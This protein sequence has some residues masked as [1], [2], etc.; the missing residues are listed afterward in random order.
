[1]SMKLIKAAEEGNVAVIK[2]RLAAGDDIRFAQKGTGFN[3]LIMAVYAGQME[4]VRCLIDESSPLDDLSNVLGW[5]ALGWAASHGHVQA[6]QMLKDAGADLE[7]NADERNRTPYLVAIDFGKWDAARWFWTAG[8]DL[9]VKDGRGMSA[10]DL[11]TSTTRPVPAD[12]MQHAA[13]DA[14]VAPVP[15]VS[16]SP[17]DDVQ[18]WPDEPVAQVRWP[19][20]FPPLAPQFSV[21]AVAEGSEKSCFDESFHAALAQVLAPALAS[22]TAAVRSWVFTQSHWEKTSRETM[23]P[24]RGDDL[25]PYIAEHRRQMVGGAMIRHAFLYPRARRAQQRGLPDVVRIRGELLLQYVQAQGA[26][27]VEV[28]VLARPP[29]AADAS[30]REQLQALERVQELCFTVMRS[31]KK[32]QTPKWRVDALKMRNY[33]SK[34]WYPEPL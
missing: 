24:L 5:T 19:E 8:A 29:L 34:D 18:A 15:Q 26:N 25:P 3:A 9:Q 30:E 14:A 17:L 16:V 20:D 12:V 11:L 32:G 13:K 1:M 6:L 33:G 4:A 7:K 31:G 21:Q 28:A 2:K 23:E 22:P 10:H 27:K